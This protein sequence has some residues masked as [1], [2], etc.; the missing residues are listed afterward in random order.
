MAIRQTARHMT[1][2]LLLA[3][4]LTT[5]GC[6]QP[7]HGADM[8]NKSLAKQAEK[9]EDVKPEEKKLSTV[10]QKK[11]ISTETKVEQE[12]PKRKKVDLSPDK[13][14]LHWEFK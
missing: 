5:F 6:R 9:L 4:A 1:T 10:P 2:T 13:K 11:D 12:E 3:A 7:L 14:I 8:T